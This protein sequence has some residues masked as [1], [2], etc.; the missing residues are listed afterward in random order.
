MKKE[1]VLRTV[2]HYKGTVIAGILCIVVLFYVGACE[3]QVQSLIVEDAMVNRAELGLEIEGLVKTAELRT[4]DL[5]KQDA[6]K[7]KIAEVGLVIAAGGTVNPVGVGVS[8]AGIMGV[9]LLVD[10]SKKDSI[11]KVLQNNKKT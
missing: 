9:G 2:R 3:S 7:K 10:N 6:I 11:I 8:L 1:D 4:L 5:D